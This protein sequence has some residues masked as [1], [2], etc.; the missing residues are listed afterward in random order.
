VIIYALKIH[1]SRLLD[2]AT[3]FLVNLTGGCGSS[4]RVR[5]KAP[6]ENKLIVRESNR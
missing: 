5:V 2:H 6:Q 1:I 4:P 3:L